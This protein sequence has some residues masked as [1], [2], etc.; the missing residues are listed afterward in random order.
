MNSMSDLC[1]QSHNFYNDA[2]GLYKKNSEEIPRYAENSDRNKNV[3]LVYNG[4]MLL[5]LPSIK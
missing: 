1:T 2:I 3:H 5:L 4:K